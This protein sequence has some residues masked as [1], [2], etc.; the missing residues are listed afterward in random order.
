MIR[1]PP[2]NG[3]QPSRL[4]LPP[5]SWATVLDCLC[6][7]FPAIDRGE[8][9]ERIAR[10]LVADAAARPIGEDAPYRVGMEIQ[11]YREVALEPRVPFVE[12][13]VHV[14]ADL[15]VADKPHFLPVTPGGGHVSE[16][17]LARLVRR[18]DNPDLV[19]LHRLDR[20]TAGLV[21]F[22]ANPRTRTRYQALFREHRVVKRYEAL[23]PA[24]PAIA[25][26]CERATRLGRGEPFFLMREVD[27]AANTLTRI[28]VL[29]RTFPDWR[30]ALEPVTGR[31][32]QLRVHMAALGAP[33]LNDDFYPAP[34]SDDP[35][36]RPAD[37]YER[38][39]K[40]LATSVAFVDPFSGE[41]R[42]FKTSL[43]LQDPPF[44]AV[45]THASRA[46]PP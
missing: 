33:I 46:P 15:V 34:L 29:Q 8:W 18:F 42:E 17:L 35:A 25:F 28:D 14:D 11:Y 3:V 39:L 32:H 24:L 37:D 12:G 44:D 16:T 31:T 43:R 36:T 5:G 27:G 22:S 13:I 30:Y 7:H 40:L 19:P 41:T 20:M 21:L 38:P 1:L 2:R 9:R 26:P 4:Q 23:A 10:G 6:A 45:R